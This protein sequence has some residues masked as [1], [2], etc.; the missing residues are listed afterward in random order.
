MRSWTAGA[1]TLGFGAFKATWLEVLFATQECFPIFQDKTET[2]KY[3]ER[4]KKKQ[5]KR[6]PSPPMKVGG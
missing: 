1:G 3:W 2:V 6:N 5:T 4:K